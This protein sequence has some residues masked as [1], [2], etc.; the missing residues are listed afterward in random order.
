MKGMNEILVPP[1]ELQYA[2]CLTLN[3]DDI[4]NA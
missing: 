4:T 2:V 3:E 1:S